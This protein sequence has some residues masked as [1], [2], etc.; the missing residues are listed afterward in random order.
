MAVGGRGEVDANLRSKLTSP[1][2][3]PRTRDLELFSNKQMCVDHMHVL[4][5]AG[6]IT[7]TALFEMVR[8]HCR[9]LRFIRHE[10]CSTTASSMCV[11]AITSN[12]RVVSPPKITILNPRPE[13]IE[14]MWVRRRALRDLKRPVKEFVTFLPGATL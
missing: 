11:A 10:L 2:N 9:W 5:A 8:P 14:K 13:I 6:A 3:H 4:L 1:L 7:A 12:V